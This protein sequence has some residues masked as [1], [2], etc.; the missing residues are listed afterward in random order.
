MIAKKDFIALVQKGWENYDYAVGKF[1]VDKKGEPSYKFGKK[2]KSM[3]AIGAAAVASGDFKTG[4]NANEWANK[5][6]YVYP[7][8]SGY[9]L[10]SKVADASNTAGSKKAA[11][12]AIKKIKWSEFKES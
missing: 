1:F 4:I 8:D 5:N 7:K 6:L 9:S 12:A 3:C 11:I 2:T 10:W